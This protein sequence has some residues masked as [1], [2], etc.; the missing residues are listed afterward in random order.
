MPCRHHCGG[1]DPGSALHYTRIRLPTIHSIPHRHV[2]LQYSHRPVVG[3]SK[4]QS[5]VRA[6]KGGAAQQ[7]QTNTCRQLCDSPA[8][9]TASAIVLCKS[10]WC[11]HF[12]QGGVS[13]TSISRTTLGTVGEKATTLIYMALHYALLVACK[14]YTA[15]SV[16]HKT[17]PY[18][19][20]FIAALTGARGVS[21]CTIISMSMPEVSLFRCLAAD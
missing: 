7:A 11:V 17:D 20:A 2:H 15:P 3:R 1:W 21:M 12:E 9:C 18:L 6:W 4:H 8:L 16:Y 10:H 19:S 13:I 14:A 5:D